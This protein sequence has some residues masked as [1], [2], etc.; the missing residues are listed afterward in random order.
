MRSDRGLRLMSICHLSNPYTVDEHCNST[1]TI[2]HIARGARP[3]ASH[4][5]S[6]SSRPIGKIEPRKFDVRVRGSYRMGKRPVETE[7]STRMWTS[8]FSFSPLPYVRCPHGWISS[9]KYLERDSSGPNKTYN[10]VGMTWLYYKLGS[11]YV[12]HLNWA[13][14]AAPLYGDH[15]VVE[16]L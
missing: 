12:Y 14:W 4:L 5:P 1:T 10:Q 15:S 16:D 9:R 6:T 13:G 7:K 3:Y 2:L 8:G 11:S